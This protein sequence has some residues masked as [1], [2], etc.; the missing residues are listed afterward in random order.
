MTKI[1]KTKADVYSIRHSH[2]EGWADIFL[3]LGDKSVCVMIES[4]YGNFCY[5]TQHTGIDPKEFLIRSSNDCMM[6]KLFGENYEIADT[7]KYEV[8][9]KHDILEARK[10]QSLSKTEARDAW[11]DMLGFLECYGHGTVLKHELYSHE[12]F[13]AVFG[14]YEFMLSETIVSPHVDNVLKHIWI[15]FVEKLKEEVAET[16]EGA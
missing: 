13:E 15:P 4:D 12:H 14:E 1:Y 5:S 3:L 2:G 10:A 8:S 6:R 7:S 11:I 9:I 16:K